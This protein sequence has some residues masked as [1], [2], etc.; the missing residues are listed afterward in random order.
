MKDLN[1]A[2]VKVLLTVIAVSLAILA[3]K[4]LLGSTIGEAQAAATRSDATQT[5]KELDARVIRKLEAPGVQQI[6]TLGDQ[7]TFI[8]HQKDQ[9]AVVRVDYFEK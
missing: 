1:S 4:A 6:L 8:V 2:Y 3:G 7:K 5:V 9:V